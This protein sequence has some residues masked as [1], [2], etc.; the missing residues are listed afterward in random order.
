MTFKDV[1]KLDL[2]DPMF[3]HQYGDKILLSEWYLNMRI[4]RIQQQ[5]EHLRMNPGDY[6]KLKKTMDIEMACMKV[7]SDNVFKIHDG[8]REVK[9]L[10]N[11]NLI[12]WPYIDE[13]LEKQK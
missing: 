12:Q 9:D 10:I 1:T 3:G 2:S 8:K 5:F 7:F 4:K 6:D 11:E 13:L